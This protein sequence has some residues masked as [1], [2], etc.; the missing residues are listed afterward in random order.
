MAKERGKRPETDAPAA[1]A[2]YVRRSAEAIRARG[3][4]IG[5]PVS[6]HRSEFAALSEW[7]SLSGKRLSFSFIEQFE[8]VGSGAEHRV[9]HDQTHNVAVKATHTNRFGHSTYGEG[10][11]ATPSEYLR[12]L[13]WC[14][15]LFGDQFR[16]LGVALDDEDQMEVVCSQPWIDAHP[17]RSV[18]FQSE[19]NSYFGR[20]GFE[21]MPAQPD[22]PMFYHS[23]LGLIVA[24]AHDT[25]ILRAADEDFAAIDVIVGP[26]GP[27]LCRELGL[28]VNPALVD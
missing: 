23:E 22:A 24:D 1:A 25:N 15:R 4:R 16:I 27:S 17:I 19:I 9:Y 18:P 5:E 6:V 10:R 21:R 11:Q 8:P 20:F 26:P 28:P 13:A 12:R 2:R 3:A 7:A 14:N